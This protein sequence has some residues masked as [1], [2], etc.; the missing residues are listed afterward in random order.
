MKRMALGVVALCLFAG[1]PAFAQEDAEGCKDHPLFSRFPNMYLGGCESSQ[2]DLR[3]F[4]TGP[5]NKGT[6]P[7]S[8]WRSRGRS[9]G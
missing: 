6:R 5:I 2:F 8:R 1:A 4:P 3:A 7:P 9:S